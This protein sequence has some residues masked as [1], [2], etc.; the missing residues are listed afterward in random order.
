MAKHRLPM[1]YRGYAGGPHWSVD[2]VKRELEKDK[3]LQTV[4]YNIRTNSLEHDPEGR[5]IVRLTEEEY[6]ELYPDSEP[7][8][9]QE[10]LTW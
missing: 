1:D 7:K 5:R 3:Y 9:H 6:K 10:M 2:I 4:S 8:G